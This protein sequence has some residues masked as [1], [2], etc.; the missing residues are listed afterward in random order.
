MERV[1]LSSYPDI[2]I[3]GFSIVDNTSKSLAL[4]RNVTHKLLLEKPG[5]PAGDDQTRHLLHALRFRY[6]MWCQCQSSSRGIAHLLLPDPSIDL[7]LWRICPEAPFSRNKVVVS[8]SSEYFTI[9]AAFIFE[10]SHAHAYNKTQFMDECCRYLSVLFR[11]CTS[12]VC[13]YQYWVP[14][15]KP[16]GEPINCSPGDTL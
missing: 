16:A 5:R 3:Q 2:L 13:P 9:M 12:G 10:S 6:F 15:Q 8:E 11:A 1:F 7:I 4:I 14:M